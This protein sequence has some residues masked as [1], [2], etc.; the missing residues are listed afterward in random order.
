MLLNPN[1][2]KQNTKKRA[3]TQIKYFYVYFFKKNKMYK[4]QENTKNNF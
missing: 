2:T 1:K 3:I 4:I